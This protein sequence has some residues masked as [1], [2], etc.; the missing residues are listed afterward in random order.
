MFIRLVL[1]L[2]IAGSSIPE[3]VM[4]TRLQEKDLGPAV[5]RTSSRPPIS[6]EEG[7][8]KL[9]DS[10]AKHRELERK[11]KE[12]ESESRRRRAKYRR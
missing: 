3:P 5:G 4:D 8:R 11:L 10:I 9:M 6:E 1:M 2:S 7:Y 12:L